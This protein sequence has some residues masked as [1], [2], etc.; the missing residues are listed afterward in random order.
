[1]NDQSEILKLHGKWLAL[2]ASGD[3]RDVLGLCERDVVW[4][5]P[6]LGMLEGFDEISAFLGT[7][8]RATSISI[9]TY[10]VEIEVSGTL[11]VKRARF[12]TTMMDAASQIQVKGAH[13]WTL[14]KNKV[15][16]QWQVAS[17]AWSIEG[18]SS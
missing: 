16:N 14:R 4:L 8:S 13:I 5:I 9:E 7:E 11:A 3:G 10:D 1:M 12:R 15:S 17:V 18:E 2:E 6:G